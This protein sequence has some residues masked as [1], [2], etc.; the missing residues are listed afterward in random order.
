MLSSVG[1][2]GSSKKIP[3]GSVPQRTQVAWSIFSCDPSLACGSKERD[4]GPAPDL[5]KEGEEMVSPFFFTVSDPKSRSS[6]EGA[7]G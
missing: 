3:G 6:M 7:E 4:K 1:G 2:G 5:G